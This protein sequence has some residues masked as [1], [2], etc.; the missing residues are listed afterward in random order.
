VEIVNNNPPEWQK[1]AGLYFQKWQET[2]QQLIQNIYRL[3]QKRNGFIHNDKNIFD[4]KDK[5]Q[6]LHRDIYTKEGIKS[7]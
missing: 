6:Y 5:G 1:F 7:A 2:D 4:K 3:I